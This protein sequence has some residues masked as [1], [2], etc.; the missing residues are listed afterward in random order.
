MHFDF[1]S[2]S[3][4]GRYELLLG[5][6]VPRPIALVTSLSADG[7]LNAA[8]YSLFN[9]LGTD[10]PIVA[11]VVL[12]HPDA[13]L[14]DTASNI[15]ETKEFV[16]NLISEEIGDAMNVTCIDAPPG[17]NELELA[18]L[19]TAA[20]IQVKPSRIA[21]SPIAF[22]CRFHSSIS[23]GSNQAIIIG[24][25]VN[26]YVHDQ[27]VVDR[28]R[29]LVDTPRLRLIGGMHGTRWYTRTTDLFE[30]QRPTW[31]QWISDGIVR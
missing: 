10:P 4:D 23:L 1:N 22:E 2:M 19:E 14:K 15:L 21:A 30:M 3:A 25:V 18:R 11:F 20:S 26:A 29:G 7:L 16:V 24:Q 31:A 9:V 12:P 28:A 6:V 8:P 13:R 27:F 5:S 17:T